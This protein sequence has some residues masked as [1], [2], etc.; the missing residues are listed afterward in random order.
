PG[1]ARRAARRRRKWCKGGGDSSE[2]PR[3]RCPAGGRLAQLLGVLEVE[4]LAQ[5]ARDGTVVGVRRHQLPHVA[6]PS[7]A[8]LRAGDGLPAL[9]ALDLRVGE[10]LAGL[11]IEVYGI[12]A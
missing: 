2:D 3:L 10:Q 9:L 1:A 7:P 12:A 5:L 11:G 8:D 6:P 4:H